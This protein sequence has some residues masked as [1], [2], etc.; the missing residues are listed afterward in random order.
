MPAERVDGLSLSDVREAARAAVERARRGEGPTLLHVDT[1][2]FYGH[3]NG[4][5]DSC[6]SD[7]FGA[8]QRANR[9]CLARLRRLL[10]E[11]G[12]IAAELDRGDAVEAELAVDDPEHIESG[13]AAGSRWVYFRTPWGLQME[14]VSYPCGKGYE[15]D[16]AV[17]LWS[18]RFPEA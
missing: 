3:S 9:D 8:E 16:A 2:R 4:D 10:A 14:L 12:V 11:S 5:V 18:P 13:P 1:E 15:R 7:A 6:R 17:K